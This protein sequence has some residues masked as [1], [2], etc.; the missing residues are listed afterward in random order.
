MTIT[1]VNSPMDFPG[2]V[3]QLN[4]KNHLILH[5]HG[6][7]ERFV[8][9]FLR[10]SNTLVLLSQW[11]S[12][13]IL[14]AAKV[15]VLDKFS[16]FVARSLAAG[17]IFDISTLDVIS[18][19]CQYHPWGDM[20]NDTLHWICSPVLGLCLHTATCK[21]SGCGC[22]G[23]FGCNMGLQTEEQLFFGR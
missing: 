18:G 20:V 3:I 15:N 12:S 2:L 11:K 5:Q 14:L 19:C 17:S 1:A 7:V 16:R 9:S 22:G 10:S 8:F 6:Y 23:F 4:A 21:H 13:E